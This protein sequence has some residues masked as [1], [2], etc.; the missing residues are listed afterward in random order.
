MPTID[1]VEEKIKN[2]EGFKVKFLYLDG[3]DVRGDL[4]DIPQ[5]NG[6]S[7]KAADTMTV[8]AWIERRFK[9]S[10]PGFRVAVLDADDNPVHGRTK[11]ST[12]RATYHNH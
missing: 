12:V 5:Y 10:Y 8:T 1:T 7:Y 2:F 4:R 9:S 3:S 11:L 6:Y